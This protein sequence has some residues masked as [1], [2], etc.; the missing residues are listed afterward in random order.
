MAVAVDRLLTSA[1]MSVTTD[2]EITAAELGRDLVVEQRQIGAR[3]GEIGL[4]LI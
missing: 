4:G 3:L 2:G 1:D